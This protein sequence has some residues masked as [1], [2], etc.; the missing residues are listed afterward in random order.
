MHTPTQRT[1]T[2]MYMYIP[3]SSSLLR[4]R[5]WFLDLTTTD[6]TVMVVDV[7]VVLGGGVSQ[8]V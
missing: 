5:G 4:R 6:G 3:I 8:E 7:V 2:Y 1:Y